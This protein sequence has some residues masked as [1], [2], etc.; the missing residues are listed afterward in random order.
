M[1]HLTNRVQADDQVQRDAVTRLNAYASRVKAIRHVEPVALPAPFQSLVALPQ[2][3]H[4]QFGWR[5]CEPAPLWAVSKALRDVDISIGYAEDPGMPAIDGCSTVVGRSDA[6]LQYLERV[7]AAA[8]PIETLRL[9]GAASEQLVRQALSFASLTALQLR[10]GKQLSTQVL[11]TLATAAPCLEALDIEAHHITAESMCASVSSA[12]AP[13]LF[14]A[15]RDLRINSTPGLFGMMLPLMPPS[16]LRSVHFDVCAPDGPSALLPL[17]GALVATAGSSLESLVLEYWPDFEEEEGDPRTEFPD[18]FTLDLL[19]PLAGL[20]SLRY[21]RLTAAR[22]PC[23]D[24]KDVGEIGKWW[25]QV[26]HLDL[27]TRDQR[28]DWGP[29]LT[30]GVYASLAKMCPMLKSLALPVDV[31]EFA[32]EGQPSVE[33]MLAPFGRMRKAEGWGRV[34][35]R[36]GLEEIRYGVLPDA[37][38]AVK[39]FDMFLVALFPSV[40]RTE[41]SPESAPVRAGQ[42]PH[43]AAVVHYLNMLV[44]CR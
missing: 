3:A 16:V 36:H 40:K 27:G 8:V 9:R 42:D 20:I 24:D 2:L 38:G 6:M 31:P 22:L 7:G 21:F 17:F 32:D 26:E 14:P 15:L 19:R 5:G 41:G 33:E 18:W 1:A 11:L 43:P 29:G 37:P 10:V 28:S 13:L 35:P 44:D 39:A 4:A 25:R 23:L 34:Q 12:S 30:P